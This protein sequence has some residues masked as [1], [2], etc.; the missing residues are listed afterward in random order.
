MRPKLQVTHRCHRSEYRLSPR[1]LGRQASLRRYEHPGTGREYSGRGKPAKRQGRPIKGAALGSHGS[2]FP[3]CMCEAAR[4]GN[5][6]YRRSITARP[7]RLMNGSIL[8]GIFPARA[9][10]SDSD[11]TGREP[12]RFSALLKDRHQIGTM[13]RETGLEPATFC[14]GS[15]YSTN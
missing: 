1:R 8:R 2:Q 10:P 5:H 4:E 12:R 7:G 11:Q 14:L 9:M 13:E 15:R 3:S 6:S